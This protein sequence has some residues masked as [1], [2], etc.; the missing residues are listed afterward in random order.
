MALIN[1]KDCNKE[2]SES[3]AACPSCGSPIERKLREGEEQCPWCMEIVDEKASTCPG[4]KAVKGI[5][6][7]S[8]Y[9]VMGKVGVIIWGIIFPLVL[10]AAFPPIG[11]VL[12]P[13]ALYSAFR[14]FVTGHRWFQTRHTS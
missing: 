10:T 5:M 9:G 2:I 12:V 1:C 13:F 6:Y 8:R 11:I 14:V 4:C 7:E 3:A